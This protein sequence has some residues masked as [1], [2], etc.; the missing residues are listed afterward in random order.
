MMQTMRSIENTLVKF[1]K[2]ARVRMGQR[3]I[4]AWMIGMIR[5]YGRADGDRLV[6]DRREAAAALRTL[7]SERVALLKVIDKG[8]VALVEADDTIV[9]AYNLNE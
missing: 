9:T 7:D 6:L 1:S 3:G 4:P 2:H 5:R 8:G